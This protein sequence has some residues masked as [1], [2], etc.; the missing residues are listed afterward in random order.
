[1]VSPP[2]GPGGDTWYGQALDGMGT[3]DASGAG[4]VET[5]HDGSSG[6]KEGGIDPLSGFDP[7]LEALPETG[8]AE[9]T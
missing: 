7:L 9:T 1:M 2:L 8:V 4:P 6:S 5:H 3:M